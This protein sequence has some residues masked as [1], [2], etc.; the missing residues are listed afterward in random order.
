MFNKYFTE[1]GLK[2]SSQITETNVSFK[3][4]MKFTAHQSFNNPAKLLKDASDVVAP[5]LVEIFNSSL[6]NGIFPDELKIARIT[7]IHK[8]GDKKICGNY[9]PISILSIVAKVF[10]KLVCMQLNS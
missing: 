8:F 10:E 2:L 9:R 3:R 1:I 6:R 5:F 7:P 4:Y